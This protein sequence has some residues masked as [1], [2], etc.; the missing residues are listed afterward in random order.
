MMLNTV[1]QGKVNHSLQG[2]YALNFS[3]G[4]VFSLRGWIRGF[5][6]GHDPKG[7]D[8]I[9]EVIIVRDLFLL[10]LEIYHWPVDEYDEGVPFEVTFQ[11]GNGESNVVAIGAQ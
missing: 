5:V 11:P 3:E 9:R 4:I 8:C 6:Y 2:P 7:L 10:V 1:I